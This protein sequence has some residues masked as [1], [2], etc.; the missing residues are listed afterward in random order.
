MQFPISSGSTRRGL[1]RG[2]EAVQLCGMGDGGE[3]RIQAGG[4]D[5]GKLCYDQ[6]SC[7]LVCTVLFSRYTRLR[8]AIDLVTTWKVANTWEEDESSNA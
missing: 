5:D 3:V 8:A 1:A 6:C 7:A 4:R 2:E